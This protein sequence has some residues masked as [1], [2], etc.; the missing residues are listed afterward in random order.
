MV[1]ANSGVRWLIRTRRANFATNAIIFVFGE[2]FVLLIQLLRN[3][4]CVCSVGD[5]DFL[6]SIPFVF[7]RG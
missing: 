6:L 7:V 4:I 1:N 5:S 3:A 2:G